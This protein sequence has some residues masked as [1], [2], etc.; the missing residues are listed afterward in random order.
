MPQKRYV[1]V[2]VAV[3]VETAFTA[4]LLS[5][6]ATFVSDDDH[7]ISLLV[8]FEILLPST[9]ITD[10][11][12]EC[13]SLTYNDKLESLRDTLGCPTITLQLSEYV[14]PA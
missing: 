11:T 14:F 1:A 9:A 5:T 2:I 12:I 7:M 13:V 6:V 8:S 4:P 3:P 10:A